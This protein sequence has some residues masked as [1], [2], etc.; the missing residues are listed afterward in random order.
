MGGTLLLEIFYLGPDRIG[1]VIAGAARMQNLGKAELFEEAQ[2][3]LILLRNLGELLLDDALE[4]VFEFVLQGADRRWN[5]VAQFLIDLRSL[6]N[7]VVHWRQVD[8]V[9]R[10]GFGELVSRNVWLV[11]DL[12]VV[13]NGF[14]KH[15]LGFLKLSSEVR[16][17]SSTAGLSI[18]LS[19]GKLLD[20]DRQVGD[21]FVHSFAQIA[22]FGEL[23]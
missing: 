13:V 15:R 8:E 2:H 18:R 1:H 19:L 12:F 20:T 14:G 17:V 11:V 21:R 3:L 16:E 10:I 4:H 23:S 9:L 5:N 7:L 6:V 22:S